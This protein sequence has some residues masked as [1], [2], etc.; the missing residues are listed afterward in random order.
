MQVAQR[1]FR[2]RCYPTD[3]QEAVLIQ[4]WGCV[5]LVFNKALA[6]RSDVWKH[7]QHSVSYGET[8]AALTRWKRD[9]ELAFLREVSTV[10][11]QQSL[12]HLQRA[13]ANF[14]AKR[15]KYPRFKAKR[16]SNLSLE[17]TKSGFRFKAGRLWLAKMTEP[18]D[19][20]VSRDFPM[21][22]A[23]SVAVTQD[24]AGRWH[25]SILC[26][27]QV[28]SLPATGTAVGV[29]LGVTDALVLSNGHRLNPED[30]FNIR[31]KQARVV[32][33]QRRLAKK[34]RGSANYGRV[35]TKLAQAHA[36][37]SD[38]RHDWLHKTTT[39][40][41]RDHDVIVLEDL[42]VAGMTRSAKGT[43]T[44]PGKNVAAKAGLN[45]GILN[46]AFGQFREFLEYKAHW[47]GKQVV[48]LDRYYPSSKTCSTCGQLNTQLQLKDRTW[49]CTHCQTVH[50]RDLNA[51]TN[52]LA[53]GLAV[54][55]CGEDVKPDDHQRTSGSPQ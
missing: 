6:W 23:T 42:N 11:L 15:A 51:A 4:T 33:Y 36:N 45:R 9:P 22:T 34:T 38:A 41:V 35:K 29:D 13:F 46:H 24:A 43:T 21:E 18:L 30:D 16:R 50:D 25:V 52:I 5:R 19:V 28:E 2:F 39:S 8:S 37:L 17:Y 40:L 44:K 49:T 32:K 3:A 31:A 12:R 53:A 1:A 54:T 27:D 14:F 10:P 55:A 26:T 47:Y 48:V 20:R 7:Q